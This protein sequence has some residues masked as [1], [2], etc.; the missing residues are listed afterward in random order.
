[1]LSLLVLLLLGQFSAGC[2]LS[3]D[4]GP[5]EGYWLGDHLIFQ[6]K[7]GQ[8][9]EVGTTN[10]SCNDDDGACYAD[11]NRFF[12]QLSFVITGMKFSG[13]LFDEMVGTVQIS[14]EFESR[15]YAT[16]TYQFTSASGCCTASGPWRAEFTQPYQTEEPDVGSDTGESDLEPEEDLP[17]PDSAYPP[18]A[19]EEQI[20]AILYVNEIRAA[21]EI[22]FLEE[23]KPINQ[24]AQAHAE[25]FEGHC[26][27]YK[28]E[29]LSPHSENPQ[30]PEG[31]TGQSFYDRM[32]HFG[33]QG[34]PGWEVMAFMG[35]PIS[36]VDGWMETLYH[37]IPFVHPNA[38]ETGYGMTQGGCYRWSQGTDVMNFSK[39]SSTPVNDGVAYPYDGQTNV[40]HLWGGNESPQPPMPPGSG[41]P[42]GPIVTL[43]FPEGG[44]FSVDEHLLIAPDNSQV[45]H[46]WVTPEND[47]AGFLSRTVSLYSL[48]P[49]ETLT[50]Y[51]VKMTGKWKGEDRVWEWSFTT[52][53]APSH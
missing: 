38:F 15:T 46:M 35:N 37:R 18:S 49:L 21:L 12:P 5:K 48:D 33:F 7:D 44:N 51:T 3:G 39:M 13:S 45:P 53:D 2:S 17:P 4:S 20:Q 14:G 29:G 24:A 1:L 31:F 23:I 9:L 30:W 10:I 11:A 50:N 36:A 25:Y 19:T 32:N 42:S 40:N 16:G 47:P 34:I 41:Y 26:D 28:S 43:T 27:Q 8:V 6:V 22:P 52:G